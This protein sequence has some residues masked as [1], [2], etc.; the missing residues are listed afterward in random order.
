MQDT[1]QVLLW[2]HQAGEMVV[3]LSSWLSRCGPQGRAAYPASDRSGDC[4][5][6]H[7][8]APLHRSVLLALKMGGWPFSPIQHLHRLYFK[9]G[10]WMQSILLFGWS[11]VS[12]RPLTSVYLSPHSLYQ[13]ECSYCWS[14]SSCS[15]QS[16]WKN[17]YSLTATW[18]AFKWKLTK[19]KWLHTFQ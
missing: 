16:A 13:L 7:V 9:T 4:Q 5:L 12:S 14:F 6:A 11:P 8:E 17:I 19:E 18:T 3:D 2:L 15:F 10:W 1:L